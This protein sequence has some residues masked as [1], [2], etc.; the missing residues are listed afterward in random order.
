MSTVY[1]EMATNSRP[2]SL[3]NDIFSVDWVKG[4]IYLKREMTYVTS[5]EESGCNRSWLVLRHS[6][7]MHQENL[8]K[9]V[10]SSS[11]WT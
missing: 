6:L 5:W 11:G 10:K 8:R 7:I 4:P 2:T 9:I 3:F 1:Y